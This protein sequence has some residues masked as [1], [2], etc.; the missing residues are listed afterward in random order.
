MP[1]GQLTSTHMFPPAIRK[2]FVSGFVLFTFAAYA[3]HEQ[4][5]GDAA[6][7]A[8]K[9]PAANSQGNTSTRQRGVQPRGAQPTTVPANT[10]NTANTASTGQ[11]RDGT[12]TGAVADAYFGQVQVQAVVQ[13]GKLTDVQFLNYPH[14]RRT[15]QRINNVAMPYLTNEAVQAQTARVDIISG[16]TLTSEAFIQSLQ[17]ALNQAQS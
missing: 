2:Y 4:T 15:S 5:A 14:D 1:K 8:D 17:T 7:V 3:I 11:F 6:T 16:A 10:A 13:N 9:A 12:Y